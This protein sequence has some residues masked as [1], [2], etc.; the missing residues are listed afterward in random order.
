MTSRV[1]HFNIPIDDP[2]RAGAFYRDMFAWDVS[3]WGPVDYWTMSAGDE[4]GP[5][6]EGALT[7]R[8]EAPEG[9]V[10]YVGVD[11]IDAALARVTGA[12]GTRLTERMPIPTMGWMAH[13][14]D[15]EGNLIGLFQEDPT[16]AMPVSGTADAG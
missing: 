4:P 9:V 13:I 7:P 15:S 14:R 12:G 8:S 3:K 6:A 10:I 2:A 5:G 1:V 11:D 16:V